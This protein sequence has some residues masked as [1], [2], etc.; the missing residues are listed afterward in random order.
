[1]KRLLLV[2]HLLFLTIFAHATGLES[3][4]I[5]IDGIQWNLLGRPV[6]ADSVL[7]SNLKAV[8]PENRPVATSN[9]DGFTSYWSI[10]QDFLCLDS[11]R[12]ENY[13][14]GKMV[15]KRIPN[16]TTNNKSLTL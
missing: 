11:I 6:C 15:S 5:F 14:K 16:D 2:M 10:K 3:D 8:L 7:Y 9:W 4:I 12:C 1:M 13:E